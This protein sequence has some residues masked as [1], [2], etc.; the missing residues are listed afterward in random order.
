MSKKQLTGNIYGDI[1]ALEYIG[2]KRYKCQCIK[3]GTLSEQY[4]TN[5]KGDLRCKECDKGYRVDLTGNCYGFLT[6]KWVCECKCGRKTEVKANNLKHN[7]TMS[8]G[9]C[10][11]IELAQKDTVGGTRVSQIGKKKNKNNTSGYTGVGRNKRKSKWYASIR[12]CG[13]NYWLGYYDKIEDAAEARRMAEDKLY[14]DFLSWYKENYPERWDK[15]LK[16]S[17]SKY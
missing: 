7:N 4:S 1:R 6:K 14:G 9:R 15:L 10:K 11:Y 12:F 13:K 3:C 8:C 16:K 17:N 5:L 2:N